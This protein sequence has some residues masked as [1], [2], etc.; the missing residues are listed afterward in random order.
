M[1]NSSNTT[2]NRTLAKSDNNLK[3]QYQITPDGTVSEVFDVN[4]DNFIILLT[5]T[6][7]YKK[8][9]SA[10]KAN[11]NHVTTSFVQWNHSSPVACVQPA[12]I[13]VIKNPSI[14]TI[15]TMDVT[16][17]IFPYVIIPFKLIS[18]AIKQTSKKITPTIPNAIARYLIENSTCSG[19]LQPSKANKKPKQTDI[20]AI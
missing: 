5:S 15:A 19:S 20:T 11:K 6:I 18:F 7:M 1:L 10:I 12:T 9:T 14:T 2:N 13:A 17:T 3:P 8:V 16:P 4:C